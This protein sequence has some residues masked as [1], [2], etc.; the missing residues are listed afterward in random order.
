MNAELLYSECRSL[1]THAVP[2]IRA[3]AT[4]AS[5]LHLVV[6]GGSI[7]TYA[8]HPQIIRKQSPGLW[9]IY[10]YWLQQTLIPITESCTLMSLGYSH[11][12]RR[13]LTDTDSPFDMFLCY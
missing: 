7:P 2:P 8:N 1:Q 11:C 12:I 4:R 10:L 3:H 6:L 13:L 5:A 9:R